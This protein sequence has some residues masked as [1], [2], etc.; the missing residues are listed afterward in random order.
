MSKQELAVSKKLFVSS[1]GNKGFWE[2]DVIS[3]LKSIYAPLKPISFP[4]FFRL[5]A[6][7][8]LKQPSQDFFTSS[9]A[10]KSTVFI[11]FHMFAVTEDGLYF[12]GNSFYDPDMEGVD[13]GPYKI[14]CP[15]PF[16]RTTNFCFLIYGFRDG[17]SHAQCMM[18][19][20]LAVLPDSST[21]CDLSMFGG[22]KVIGR[23]GYDF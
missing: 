8:L 5:S 4:H 14:E 22:V 1:F 11:S 6:I 9:K 2:R 20:D 10:L 3:L 13:C 23:I 15:A 7:M 18:K 21:D 19:S 17:W 12:T 16:L